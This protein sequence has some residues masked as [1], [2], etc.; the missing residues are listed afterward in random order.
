M[1]SDL[2]FLKQRIFRPYALKLFRKL[3]KNQILTIDELNE[4]NWQKRKLLLVHAYDTVPYYREKFKNAG[5]APQDIVKPEDWE[6]VPILTRTDL[7]NSK[8]KM[9]SSQCKKKNLDPSTTGGSSGI[10]TTVFHDRRYPLET[11]GW[12]MMTWWNLLPGSDTAF[13]WRLIRTGRID[14]LLNQAIWWPTKRI[15]LDAASISPPQMGNFIHSFNLLK[16]PL[17]QGYVGAIHHL[18]SYIE[19]NSIRVHFPE[20]VWVTSSPM[21]LVERSM[22]QR[23]FHAPV[24]D[25]YGCGEIFWIAAQCKKQ[26]GL[27]IFYDAR[28]VEFLDGNG[29]SCEAGETGRIIITDLENYAFP[30][31]RYENGDMGRALSYPCSCGV[32]LPLMDSVKGRVTDLIRL[33]DGTA[34]SGDYLTTL[35]D[36]FPE[37]VRAFQVVQDRDYSISIYV[38]PNQNCSDICDIV[39]RR[40]G[41]KTQGQVTVSIN[42]VDELESD[43]GKLRY[44]IS[45]VE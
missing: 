37:A 25:Q 19:K 7:V 44:V 14:R 24:Y 13:V 36:D 35:F 2:F 20:A 23:V 22:I 11:L 39:K 29:K 4:L 34:V 26:G 9:I 27:H 3:L 42:I 30:L 21:S 32:K 5:I 10:P 43:R 1:K 40:L 15:W 6:H 38:V 17:L 8:E 33:P 28:H 45:Y 18:A 41:E 12:R 16:P 31:I